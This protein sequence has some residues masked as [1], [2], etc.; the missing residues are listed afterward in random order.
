MTV[1]MC[2]KLSAEHSWEWAEMS[3]NDTQNWDW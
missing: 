2:C 1:F 3:D